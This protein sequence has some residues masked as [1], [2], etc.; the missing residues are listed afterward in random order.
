MIRACAARDFEAIHAIINDAARAYKG[1]IPA[2]RWHEPYM[3]RTELQAEI[4]AGVAFSGFQRDGRLIGVMGVQPVRDVTLIRHAYVA[5]ATQRHGIGSKLLTRA[6]RGVR[7]PVLIGTWAA[8]IW[9]IAFYAKHGFTVVSD[10]EKT[11]LLKAYWTVPDHQI[12]ASVV[13]ADRAWFERG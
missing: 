12:E 1:V 11:R 7:T 9:A 10:D 8:A 4:A 2:D 6:R 13:L 3:P 5:R